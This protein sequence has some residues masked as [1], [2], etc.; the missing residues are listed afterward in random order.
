MFKDYHYFPLHHPY[1]SRHSTSFLWPHAI[2]LKHN[3]LCAPKPIKTFTAATDK[4]LLVLLSVIKLL[5]AYRFISKTFLAQLSCTCWNISAKLIY[6]MCY[7][8]VYM[9][10]QTHSP[11]I[12]YFWKNCF[13]IFNPVAQLHLNIVLQSIY[14]QSVSHQI[15]KKLYFCCYWELLIFK[16]KLNLSEILLFSGLK[17]DK[18]SSIG[19]SSYHTITVINWCCACLGYHRSCIN[20]L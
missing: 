20:Y 13:T 3:C 7:S 8:L 12:I 16:S 10:P 19:W 15:T 17:S 18:L 2:L 14:N 5:L 6:C 9:A 4:T 11:S 1:R